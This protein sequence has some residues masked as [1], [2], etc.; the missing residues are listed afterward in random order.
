MQQRLVIASSNA[1]RVQKAGEKL[2]GKAQ[3]RGEGLKKQEYLRH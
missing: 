2:E 1:E 3:G